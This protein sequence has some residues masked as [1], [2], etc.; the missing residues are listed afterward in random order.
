MPSSPQATLAFACAGGHFG[1]SVSTAGDVNSDGYS[2]VLVGAPDAYLGTGIDTAGGAF[3]YHGSASGVST[4]ASWYTRR[5]STPRNDNLGYRVALAGDVNGD[6]Y[7]DIL[8]GSPNGQSSLV[9]LQLLPGTSGAIWG[10]VQG[11]LGSAAGVG[12]LFLDPSS[13]GGA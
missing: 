6:G 8:A 5:A 7:S 10:R 3:V 4:T 11:W 12:S 9:L 2:D 1:W 13:S